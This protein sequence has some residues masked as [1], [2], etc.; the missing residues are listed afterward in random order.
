LFFS[1]LLSSFF[2]LCFYF[3]DTRALLQSIKPKNKYAATTDS[4]NENDE[5]SGNNDGKSQVSV[6][7]HDEQIVKTVCQLYG[8]K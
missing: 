7:I 5:I 1:F 4:E 6:P 2:L 3:S 8:K